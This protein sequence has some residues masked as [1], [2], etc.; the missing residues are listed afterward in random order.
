M[1]PADDSYHPTTILQSMQIVD[2]NVKNVEFSVEIPQKTGYLHL[3]A[4][5]DHGHVMHRIDELDEKHNML[6][7]FIKDEDGGITGPIFNKFS[8]PC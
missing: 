8:E 6:R 4:V 7:A 1:T 5:I 2:K 3:T